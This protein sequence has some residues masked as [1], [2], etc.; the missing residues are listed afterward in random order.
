MIIDLP[1]TATVVYKLISTALTRL[2]LRRYNKEVVKY[3]KYMIYWV[4][5]VEHTAWRIVFYFLTLVRDIN[6]V[7]K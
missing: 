1:K 3:K 6:H 7:N 5:P 4:H 2:T